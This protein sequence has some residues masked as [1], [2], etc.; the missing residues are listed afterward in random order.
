[1]RSSERSTS[2]AGSSSSRTRSGRAR[3]DYLRRH[4]ARRSPRA[5]PPAHR[6]R[7]DRDLL[8]GLRHVKIPDPDGNAIA[9]AVPPER[10][11]GAARPA[12]VAALVKTTAGDAVRVELE[13]RGG[14]PSLPLLLPY[15]RNPLD[16]T[17]EFGHLAAG[18]SERRIWPS[19]CCFRPH[20]RV[21]GCAQ[22]AA[23]SR[24]RRTRSAPLAIG[25]EADEQ[26][27][28]REGIPDASDGRE[29]ASCAAVPNPLWLSCV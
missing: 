5:S 24:Q 21:A 19:S 8:E 7:T 23:R 26:S 18:V 13:H 20:T 16:K 11:N 15:R 28:V 22:A 17:F 9:F 3:P 2:M 1:M 29:R 12:A 27:R 6:A 14:G 25:C 4:W 10:Q